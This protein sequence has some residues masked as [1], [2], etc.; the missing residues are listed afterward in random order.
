MTGYEVD[1]EEQ[2]AYDYQRWVTSY[3][4]HTD[5]LPLL[6]E[7]TG[8][9]ALPASGCHGVGRRST[10][11]RSPAGGT[12]TASPSAT[13]EPPTT[14]GNCG[15][16]C[17]GYLEQVHSRL[18]AAPTIA[19]RRAGERRHRPP[20]RVHRHR[21]ARGRRRAISD[22][23][24]V[25]PVED[26]LFALI[27]RL[28]GRYATAGTARRAHPRTCTTCGEAAVVV[29]W[30]D[31]ANGSPRP[32]QVGVCRSCGE[33]YTEDTNHHEREHVM[34]FSQPKSPLTSAACSTQ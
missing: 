28:R 7:T 24:D 3:V 16:C 19:P 33:I 9:L 11:R 10:G 14:P 12:T 21:V 22:L 5:Q 17:G 4:W 34:T 29:D 23:H 1:A 27:R 8:T 31:G 6:I 15:P 30:M 18:P 25:A 32:V 2:A 13:G 26:D 20:D